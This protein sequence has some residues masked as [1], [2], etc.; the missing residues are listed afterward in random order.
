MSHTAGV[1][2]VDI[3]LTLEELHEVEPVLR[4]L[5]VQTPLWKP[6]TANGYHAITYGWILGEIIRRID[7]R[8]L[9]AFFAEEIANPLAVESYIGL[10]MSQEHRVSLILNPPPPSDPTEVEMLLKTMGPGTLGYRTLTMDGAI[11]LSESSNPFNTREMHATEMPAA[12]GISE[13]RAL[14]KIYAA[15][16]GEIDGQR[17]IGSETVEHVRTERSRGA[18]LSLVIES[19]WGLGFML[20]T[21]FSPLLT[22]L[23]FGHSGAGGSLAYGDLQQEVGFAYLMN[24]MGGG[25][26]GDPRAFRLS[27]ALRKCL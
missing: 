17:L 26:T 20:D 13:A 11:V 12:N 8:T 7:G 6:G 5:E 16:V 22:S 14:A 2:V 10:P 15:T 3:S 23:S 19:A 24:Q 1:P 4:A 25:V 9:G 18:D 27:H 21:E